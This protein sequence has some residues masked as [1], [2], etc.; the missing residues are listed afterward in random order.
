[1]K[2]QCGMVIFLPAEIQSYD[3]SNV[4]TFCWL[5]YDAMMWYGDCLPA[6]I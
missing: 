4:V 1:M 2:L 6:E 5:K 3:E